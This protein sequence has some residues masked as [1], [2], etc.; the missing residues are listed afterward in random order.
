[1]TGKQRRYLKSLA[2]SMKPLAQLGKEGISENFLK[3]LD[4]MLESKEL[5]KV[6]VLESCMIP[7]KD[8]ANEVCEALNAE[9]VQAIG[10]KFTIYRESEENKQ[11][12]IPKR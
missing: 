4:D 2:H 9:F 11:I 1:M 12:E 8:A 5:I 7:A 10:R 6:N 3:M